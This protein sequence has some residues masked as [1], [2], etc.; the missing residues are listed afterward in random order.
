MMKTSN[1]FSIN[2]GTALCILALACTLICPIFSEKPTHESKDLRY[3]TFGTSVT[4]GSIIKN[5]ESAYPYLLSPNVTNVAMRASDS[6]YPS[7]CTQSM[8]KDSIY[9]VIIIEYDRRKFS[10]LLQLAKR[11]R[12]RF[13][14]AT[15]V[16]TKMW[17]LVD[18]Q[19]IARDGSKKGKLRDWLVKSEL[20]IHSSEA[21]DFVLD[22]DVDLSFDKII[23]S[24]EVYFTQAEKEYNVKVYDWPTHG[25]V[26]DLVK[27]RRP[28]FA[29]FVHPNE[30][31]H[32]VIADELATLIFEAKAKR[33]DRLGSWGEG[34]IC[35][36]WFRDGLIDNDT[37][38]FIAF[39]VPMKKF[40]EKN[41]KHALEMTADRTMIHVYN[42]FDGP[43]KLYLTY[44][45]S[46]PNRLYP[47]V[48]VSCSGTKEFVDID[49]IAKYDFP[50]HVQDTKIAC[51]LRPGKNLVRIQ[52][53]PEEDGNLSEAPFRLVG[54]A[55]TNEVYAPSK[56]YFK[57]I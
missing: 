49:T 19:V 57:P 24:R 40:D 39:N 55:V 21:L 29:D 43:R 45:A 12:Q 31:G 51:L 32:S 8:V 44:M 16:L 56:M 25:D 48:R 35:Q 22:Q 18:I 28:R 52:K 27:S 1:V 26:R 9:D 47:K 41:G 38:K 53:H 20:P 4:W 13:P 30:Y 10:T 54:I 6:T 46:Y 15:I 17:A 33:S 34:D 5:R 37:R 11:L 50:V 14:D 7:M 42:P 23:H 3:L 2:K 36:S